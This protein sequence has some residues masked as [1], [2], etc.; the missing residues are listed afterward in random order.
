MDNVYVYD[1]DDLNVISNEN[2]ETRPTKRLA[3]AVVFEHTAISKNYLVSPETDHR[4]F[5]TTSK[6]KAS[7]W[8]S[9]TSYEHRWTQP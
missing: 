4:G 3:E 5:K 1:V 6:S 2:K 7:N 9:L 8:T